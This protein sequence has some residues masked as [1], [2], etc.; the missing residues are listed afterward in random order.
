M[1]L[2]N[3]FSSS[4]AG[5]GRCIGAG[6]EELVSEVKCL[7]EFLSRTQSAL[8]QYEIERKQLRAILD[9]VQRAR[10]Q[11][12]TEL[13]NLREQVNRLGSIDSVVKRLRKV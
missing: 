13:A 7:R 4:N 9:Q 3:P 6:P 2:Q 10:E 11:S 12:S 5:E 8:D 1:E